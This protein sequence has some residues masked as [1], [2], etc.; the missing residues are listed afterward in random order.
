MAAAPRHNK[1]VDLNV[2][3]SAD[4]CGVNRRV[5]EKHLKH[6]DYPNAHHYGGAWLI[7]VDDLVAIGLAPDPEWLKREARSRRKVGH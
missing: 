5:I 2:S 3:A 7:P 6:G 1:P 4:A